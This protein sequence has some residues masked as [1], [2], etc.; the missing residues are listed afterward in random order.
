MVSSIASAA[1]SMSQARIEQAVSI[2]MMKRV[3]DVQKQ[4]GQA[5]VDMLAAPA[6]F[7]QRLDVKA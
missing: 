1:M 5:I 6:N 2:S 7:G 4:Q 3:M